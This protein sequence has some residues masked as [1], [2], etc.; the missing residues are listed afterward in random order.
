MNAQNLENEVNQAEQ[1]TLIERERVKKQGYSAGIKYVPRGANR[2]E[3]V[4]GIWQRAKAAQ[5][6][7]RLREQEL[8]EHSYGAQR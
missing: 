3:S 2:N 4:V 5:E 6:K 1:I 7:I 8:R